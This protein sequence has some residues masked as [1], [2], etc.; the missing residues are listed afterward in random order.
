MQ[1]LKELLAHAAAG[2]EGEV[3]EMRERGEDGGAGERYGHAVRGPGVLRHEK[4]RDRS[5]GAGEETDG[6][7]GRPPLA[8]AY[9]EAKAFGAAGVPMYGG[10]KATADCHLVDERDHPV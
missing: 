9:G 10:R 3:G 4:A 7:H 1:G 6:L 8:R 2:I 5:V